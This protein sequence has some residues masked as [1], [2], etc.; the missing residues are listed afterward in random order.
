MGTTYP[1]VYVEEIPSSV[2]AITGVATSIT[3][4]VG[5]ALKGPVDKALTIHNFA[6]FERL[7]GGL[8]KE[9]NVSYSVQQYFLNGGID[10]VIIRAFSPQADCS[11][12]FVGHAKFKR[13]GFNGYF[14]ASNPGNWGVNLNIKIDKDV[15][16]Y[17]FAEDDTL[18][19]LTITEANTGAIEYFPNAS[20]KP[21]SR[22]YIKALLETESNLIRIPDISFDNEVVPQDTSESKFILEP[23][24]ASDGND[25][26]GNDIVKSLK[27][28]DKVDLFN[29]LCIPSFSEGGPNNSDRRLA[30]KE[31]LTYCE[32]KRAILIVDP[33]ESWHDKDSAINGVKA[34]GDEQYVARDKN[35]AIFFP[36]VKSSDPLEENR[37]DFSINAA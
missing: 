6:D 33:P 2:R 26:I 8:W 34:T 22:R 35:A 24:S 20:T 37:L 16:S 21:D 15:D 31:A 12:Q 19:N 5:R 32:K 1:G 7:Y 23:N 27:L 18:F 11:I 30:Y 28:L 17:L 29:L 10:A 4:F 14:V 3:A 36:R 25:L 13:T 9:S